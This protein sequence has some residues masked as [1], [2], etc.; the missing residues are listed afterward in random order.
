MGFDEDTVRISNALGSIRLSTEPGT[1]GMPG[2]D[3]IHASRGSTSGASQSSPSGSHGSATAREHVPHQPS[4]LTSD[5]PPIQAS[6][7]V[8]DPAGGLQWLLLVTHEEHTKLTHFY[9]L[10]TAELHNYMQA[11][12]EVALC[13]TQNHHMTIS[14]GLQLWNWIIKRMYIPLVSLCS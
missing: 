4:I 13:I 5:I 14:D 12:P 1:P 8:F 10:V 7:S 9:L 11:R 2:F 3:S 6:S